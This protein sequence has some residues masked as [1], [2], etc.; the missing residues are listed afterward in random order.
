M[1]CV[2]STHNG[3][4]FLGEPASTHTRVPIH[5]EDAVLGYVTGSSDAARALASLLT[6]L[7][8]RESEGR[9]L[10]S[11]VLHLYR[12]INLVEQLS[13]QLAPLSNYRQ[14]VTLR[15]LKRRD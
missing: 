3:T 7:A 12:E 10:A 14:S 13:E 5:L 4:P 2:L 8:A 1:T 6:H 11:E 15:W 9:A